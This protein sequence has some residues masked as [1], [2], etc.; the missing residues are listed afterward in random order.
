MAQVDSCDKSKVSGPNLVVNGG[1]EDGDTGFNTS[2]ACSWNDIT[3]CSCHP[4]PWSE[5]N[6]Y[7]VGNNPGE[8]TPC[9]PAFQ[10]GFVG[11]PHSGNSFLMVDGTGSSAPV[12]WSQTINVQDSSYYYF[13]TWITTIGTTPNTL[14]KLQFVINGVTMPEIIDAPATPGQWISYTQL[15]YSGVTTGSITIQII[16]T[17][18]ASGGPDQ[19]DFGLDD[20]TFA[21]GCPPDSY[22]EQPDLGSDLTFC[23]TTAT[24]FTL[25]PNVVLNVGQGLTWSTGS[26][27][28]GKQTIDVTEA[29]TYYVCL[30]QGGSCTKIDSI[31]VRDRFIV[32]LGST[33]ELCDPVALTLDALHSGPSVSYQWYKDDVAMALGTS[34]TLFVN[35]AAEYKVVVTDPKC[36]TET[37][38]IIISAKTGTPTPNN[39]DFCLTSQPD[40]SI[41]FSVN[42]SG[43]YDW[44]ETPSGGSTLSGGTNTTSYMMTGITVA[45]TLY[46]EDNSYS[47]AGSVIPEPSSWGLGGAE[48]TKVYRSFD[49]LSDLEITSV[50]IKAGANWADAGGPCNGKSKGD[51]SNA[52]TISIYQNGSPMVPVI[53]K[54]DA[55]VICDTESWNLS[56]SPS[57]VTLNFS[58]PAG[59]GY[60]LRAPA[61][62][63]YFYYGSSGERSDAYSITDVISVPASAES[64]AFFDWNIEAKSSCDRIPVMAR[65]ICVLPVDFVFVKAIK[66]ENGVKIYWATAS[67]KDNSHFEIERFDGSD[68]MYIGRV[69][70]NGNSKTIINYDFFDSQVPASVVYYRVKQIDHDGN[71]D[72]SDVISVDNTSIFTMIWPN[73]TH[74]ETNISISSSQYASVLV[75]VH[76]PV[77][78]M[79]ESID[80]ETNQAFKI[81]ESY[82]N[83][84]YIITVHGNMEQDKFRLIKR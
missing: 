8:A 31:T 39:I 73:P 71:F 30:N 53:E 54:T 4:N 78:R 46:V 66:E 18:P 67:E 14:A 25:D 11:T 58:V 7:Y 23:G 15:W 51:S 52:F 41:L 38:S 45:D 3:N 81:G 40:T 48:T 42:G 35:E 29:G 79:I 43:V 50:K 59:T 60:E 69:E 61:G 33:R 26:A 28:A 24:S 64:G 36:Q 2:I 37:D 20:I 82:P 12:V 75:T 72:Y 47:P 22:V 55:K 21:L 84:I 32:D 62:N 16:D 77:G 6:Q 57:E 70:G 34:K 19:D 65:D 13:E 27:D 1:F 80:A 49:A 68:W 56:Y 83:G 9:G 76:D 74:S 17:Q 5:P 63:G 44:Y 10:S